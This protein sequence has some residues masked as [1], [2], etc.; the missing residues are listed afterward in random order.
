[1]KTIDLRDLERRLIER[2][3]ALGIPPG[4][5]LEPNDGTRRTQSKRRLLQAIA[6]SAAEQGREPPF[7]AKF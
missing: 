4:R 2:K 6:D 7:K 1:M 3:R 5:L